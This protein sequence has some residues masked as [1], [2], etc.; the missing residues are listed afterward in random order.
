MDEA[1]EQKA[2]AANV[3][4]EAPQPSPQQATSKRPDFDQS[5]AS[6]EQSTAQQER[7]EPEKLPPKPPR[8]ES[9]SA[10][11]LIAKRVG[12]YIIREEDRILGSNTEGT[13]TCPDHD[14]PLNFWY[15]K[16]Q[17]YKCLKCLI[18]EQEVHFVDHGY[19]KQETRFEEIK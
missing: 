1:E 5:E 17:H 7:A 18:N 4:N 6:T 15:E 8:K 14:M 16:E 19:K 3:G 12:E 11:E 2:A 13:L 9:L 10:A